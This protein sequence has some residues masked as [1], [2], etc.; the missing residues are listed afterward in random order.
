[1]TRDIPESVL[2]DLLK[3]DQQRRC[4][5]RIHQAV[6]VYG[7]GVML[8]PIRKGSYAIFHPDHLPDAFHVT[9]NHPEADPDQVYVERPGRYPQLVPIMTAVADLR[10]WLLDLAG[11]PD[12]YKRVILGI[13]EIPCEKS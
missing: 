2:N 4:A 9:V 6:R 8:I 1:M 10:W 13:D 7:R 3:S 12:D 11:I 5:E